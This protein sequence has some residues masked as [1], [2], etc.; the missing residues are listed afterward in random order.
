MPRT[1]ASTGTPIDT[2]IG[3]CDQDGNDLS[4]FAIAR[5]TAGGVYQSVVTLHT[6]GGTGLAG[7]EFNQNNTTTALLSATQLY[8]ASNIAANQTTVNLW[9]VMGWTHAASAVVRIHLF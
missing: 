9:Y 1:F 8:D 5:R 3:G 2:S 6:S 7:L 4:I